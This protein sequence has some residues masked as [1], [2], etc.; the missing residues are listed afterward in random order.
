MRVAYHK[1]TSNLIK[2]VYFLAFFPSVLNQK[3]RARE[4]SR[5]CEFYTR[6][7]AVPFSACLYSHEHS[8]Q[9]SS[10]NINPNPTSVTE[11]FAK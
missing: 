1:T 9:K 10:N 8:L 4:T 6:V 3:D 5:F 11:P 2:Y 7:H